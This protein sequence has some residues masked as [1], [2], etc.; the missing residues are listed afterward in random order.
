MKYLLITLG[1]IGDV[2]PFLAVADALRQRGHQAI[3][4][5]SAGYAGLVRGSGFEFAIVSERPAQPL[6]SLLE[7]DPDKAWQMV[8][9]EVFAPAT[10]P[11][12]EFIA[13]H[14][15]SG[16]CRIIA[17]WNAFGATQTGPGIPLFRVFLSPQALAEDA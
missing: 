9:Q 7:T 10:G 8:R 4:A 17:S 6:D 5:S 2:M 12:R 1:S 11:V 13:H 14:A 16:P 3:I 15:R